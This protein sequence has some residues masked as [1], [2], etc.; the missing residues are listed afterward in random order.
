MFFAVGICFSVMFFLFGCTALQAQQ[1]SSSSKKAIKVYNTGLDNYSR[2]QYREALGNLNNAVK[3]D[4][5]FVEAHLLIAECYLET[6]ELPQAKDAFLQTIAVNPDFF[7]PVY[8]SLADIEFEL[9]EYEAASKHLEQFLTYSGQKP[10]LRI[11]SEKL[12]QSSNFA[13]QAVKNPVPFQPENLGLRFNYDQYW[14][15]LSVDEHTL[16]FTALIPKD[17][18]NAAVT[19][20]RQEDFFVSDFKNGAWTRPVNLGSPPNTP[21]NEGAQSISADASE[22]F[23]TA[24]NRKDGKGGCD[25]YYSRKRDG[26]WTRPRNLG[27][28]INTSAKETQPSISSDGRTLYFVS[29]RGGGKGGQDIWMSTLDE[30]N[31]WGIP[32]NLADINTPDDE[33]SP[34]IHLD[35]KTLYFAS[36]G[37]PGMGQYDLFVTRKDSLGKWSTPENLGYPI[38]SKHNE[39]G[40][41]VNARGDRAYY[42]SDRTDDRIRR[43]FTFEL[44]PA[45]RPDPVS[46]MKGKIYDAKYYKPLKA[47]FQLVDTASDKEIIEASSDSATGEFLVC[48]P[49]GKNYALNIKCKGYLFYSEHFMMTGGTYQEPYLKDIP[50]RQIRPGEKVVLKNV[51]FDFDS[52]KL[53]DESKAELQNLAQFLR[54]NPEVKV[55][56]TGHTDNT[57]KSSYNMELSQNRAR[58]VA[59]YL[60]NEGIAMNRVSYKGMGSSEPIARNDTEEGRAQN[61]RTELIIVK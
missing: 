58:A 20:N 56:I 9:E 22:M 40:M 3:I 35:G 60:L 43:I 33:S 21:D 26:L 1:L 41:I 5:K 14:P 53:L 49:T 51:F 27:E 42:S 32:I 44:Y 55:R 31:R 25:I 48:I 61:R 13:A 46:Y 2:R 39:E 11:K 36:N 10:T 12:L 28:P 17:S 18:T 4:N 50:L 16:V 59:N 37:H 38:N 29:T 34:F 54:D 15:S 57:G 7:P 8:Y 23:F 52:H 47:L 24:C 6:G 19:G 45:I 30:K